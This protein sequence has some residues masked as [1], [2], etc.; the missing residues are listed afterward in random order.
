MA[1]SGS[2]V[3]AQPLPPPPSR[4]APAQVMLYLELVVNEQSSGKVVPV[5]FRNGH[6]WVQTETLRALHV[7]A[8]PGPDGRTAVDLI[9]G[10][11]V[12]YDSIGQR[13]KIS[14]PPEWLPTQELGDETAMQAFAASA[15]NGAL[16]NYDLYVSKPDQ[17]SANA[18]L[19]SEQRVF[20]TW[21]TVSNTGVYRDTLQ[22]RG[23]IRYDT[24]WTNSNTDDIRSYSLGDLI[25]APLAWGSA[26][27]LGGVQFARN[28]TVRPD[29]ITYPLPQ[30]RGQAAVP[31]AVD[32]F[33]NGYKAGSENV[34]PGPFAL[35]TMPYING[36]GEASM[37]TTDAL[38]RQ[39]VT[40]VPFYVANT[41]LRKD[42]TDYSFSLGALRRHYGTRNFS[43]GPAAASAAYRIGL[44]DGFTLETRAE[45]APSLLVGGVGGG[46]GLGSFGVVNAALSQ[47]EVRGSGGQQ[48][49]Y[50]YQY[51]GR[52]YGVGV[53]Q[54]MRSHG[55]SDLTNYDTA[56][57]H[58]ARRST[59]ANASLS[60]GE[61]GAFSAAY[62]DVTAADQQRTKLVSLSYN[63]S[64][65]SNIFLSI[66]ANKALGGGDLAVQLQLTFALD[67]RNMLSLGALNDGKNTG[68]QVNYSR[69]T[70]S[71]GG[72]GWNLA[73][74]NNGNTSN[75]R[76]ASGTWRT[77]YTQVQ[78]GVYAHGKTSSSWLGAMG[79]VVWMDGGLFAA[80]RINDAF[81]LVSTNGVADVPVRYENQLIGRTNRN[82]HILV[83]GVPGYYPARIE[84]DALD[85]P[86]YMQVPQSQQRLAVRSGSGALASFLIQKTLAARITLVDPLGQPMPMG[87]SVQHVQSGQNTVVGWDGLVYL[88]GLSTQNELLVRSPGNRQC[89]VV[90][91]LDVDSHE[92][93][94]I[95]P[96]T[97]KSEVLQQALHRPSSV[98]TPLADPATLGAPQPELPA[99][100]L[101]PLPSPPAGIASP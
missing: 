20:G 83:P 38:G 46:V 41:L 49:N 65:G 12:Q 78:G 68:S 84:I 94:R 73:Y 55:Y 51:N 96:L 16:L 93:L 64:L 72:L 29:L 42:L 2:P 85:L 47:S 44:S 4:N 17:A 79:S 15:S 18:S 25:A 60:L 13:L 14:V 76:Q 57:L 40:T 6:Y 58:L 1:L 97:C 7:H 82:G 24:R 8:E 80:N 45:V 92:V 95:G 69:T 66:S 32:L 3:A 34:Q 31:S 63:K 62:F 74:A 100:A 52:S 10:V 87:S 75:Y 88:E 35:N 5:Q 101:S 28:F 77:N 36:A 9:A 50:G 99:L 67:E 70:P 91:T 61:A 43:Y 54:T 27:R 90:F 11:Q 23:Y 71:D 26:V 21:G 89:R 39:V 22:E 30:F 98:T 56:G 53:Q 81:M 19:L 86:D 48:V 33:I 37:V 59:Q